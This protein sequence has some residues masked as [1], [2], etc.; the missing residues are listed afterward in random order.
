MVKSLFFLTPRADLFTTIER[1]SNERDIRL[2]TAHP[3]H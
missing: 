3:S 2:E 1:K